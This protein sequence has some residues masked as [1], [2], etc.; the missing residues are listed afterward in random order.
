MKKKKKRHIIK[1]TD[2]NPTVTNHSTI[3]LHEETQ[4]CWNLQVHHGLRHTK[5]FGG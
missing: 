5:T 3:L 4:C 1:R 2:H